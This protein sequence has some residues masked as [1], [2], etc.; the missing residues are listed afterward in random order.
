MREREQWMRLVEL[1]DRQFEDEIVGIFTRL[2]TLELRSGAAGVWM[3][4]LFWP[5][6]AAD[7]GEPTER[8]KAFIARDLSTARRLVDLLWQDIG[9]A[10][11]CIGVF[12]FADDTERDGAPEVRKRDAVDDS[13][14][15]DA[16][17]LIQLLAE[18]CR[19]DLK[20]RLANG[21]ARSDMPKFTAVMRKAFGDRQQIFNRY[22]WLL[23]GA[24]V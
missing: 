21:F 13:Q 20:R 1:D 12:N 23:D 19:D 16:E 18:A 5:L 22:P 3:D 10:P 2:R 24:V 7:D 8:A 14:A 15:A 6:I 9:H 11:G 4:L 17:S